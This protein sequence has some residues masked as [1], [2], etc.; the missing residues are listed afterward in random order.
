MFRTVEYAQGYDGE[1]RTTEVYFYVLDALPLFLGMIVW[2]VIW[3]PAI[4]NQDAPYIPSTGY[5]MPVLGAGATPAKEQLD[6]C[7]KV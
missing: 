4:L 3:P 6:W 5:S 2:A 1:L 7:E